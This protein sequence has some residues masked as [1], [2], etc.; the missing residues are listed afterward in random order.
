MPISFSPTC[1]AS[2]QLMMDST[3]VLLHCAVKQQEAHKIIASTLG[4][5]P[6]HYSLQRGSGS[7]RLK[8]DGSAKLTVT[9]LLCL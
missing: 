3:M 6:H 2:L 8:P 4:Y 7:S 1:T 9:L 5:H